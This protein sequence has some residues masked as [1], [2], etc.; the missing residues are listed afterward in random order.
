MMKVRCAV[1]MG[2]CLVI[3]AAARG[4]IK[5]SDLGANNTAACPAAGELP[6]YCK[7]PFTGQTDVRPGVAT[8]VFDAPAGNVSDEDPHNYLSQGGKTRI[9]A[10]FML[11][12][13]TGESGPRCHNNV[14]T[15]Y[16]SN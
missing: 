15:G 8:P 7:Q 6:K 3:S 13:C 4:Q 5:L 1:L 12:F 11:G 2:L 9:F 14:R 16:N 10:N